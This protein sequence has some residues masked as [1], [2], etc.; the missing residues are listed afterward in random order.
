[1]ADLEP[2]LLDKNDRDGYRNHVATWIRAEIREVNDW[3]CWMNDCADNSERPNWTCQNCTRMYHIG[4]L[5]RF[6]TVGDALTCPGCA[7]YI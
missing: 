4:C 7:L 6:R 3:R 1:M 5:Q 2:T